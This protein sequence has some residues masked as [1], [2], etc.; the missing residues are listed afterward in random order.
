MVWKRRTK[1]ND[2]ALRF[3]SSVQLRLPTAD[4]RLAE[5]P[6]LPTI[7]WSQEA[8]R[9]VSLILTF[10]RHLEG[11]K[12][13]QVSELETETET[14]H[15]PRCQRRWKMCTSFC[16]K[17]VSTLH[18]LFE[19][20]IVR[21]CVVNA[22]GRLFTAAGEKQR[23]KVLGDAHVDRCKFTFHPSIHPHP[24]NQNVEPS[25]TKPI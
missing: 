12:R 9:S 8:Q 17:K 3:R 16:T 14:E 18:V 25:Q 22:D 5:R 13:V 11:H 4:R 21:T 23:R 24:R 1:R 6:R 20:R 15:T 7:Q 19:F 2:L 10:Y